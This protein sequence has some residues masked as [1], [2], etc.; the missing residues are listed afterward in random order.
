MN[1]PQ[2]QQEN[3]PIGSGVTEAPYK[4]TLK[5]R[6]CNLGM[7]SAKEDAAIV[8]SLACLAYSENPC[9]KFWQKIDQYGQSLAT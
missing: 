7:R 6:L 9:N 8:L 3:L 1:F 4:V 2:L 5:Q